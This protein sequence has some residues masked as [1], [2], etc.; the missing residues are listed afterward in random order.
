MAEKALPE[1]GV[2]AGTTVT[3][4]LIGVLSSCSGLVGQEH[5]D[6]Y[7]QLVPYISPFLS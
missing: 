3:A 4:T 2:G 5:R 6:T 7:T 1:A